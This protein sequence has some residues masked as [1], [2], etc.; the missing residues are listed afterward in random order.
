MHRCQGRRDKRA[1]AALRLSER[2]RHPQGRATVGCALHLLVFTALL[3]GAVLVAAGVPFSWIWRAIA[4]GL[5]IEFCARAYPL[6][7]ADDD[8]SG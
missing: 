2:L 4:I 1:E 6:L 8:D 3:F 7:K 5:A